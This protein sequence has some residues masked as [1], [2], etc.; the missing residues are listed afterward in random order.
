M[1]GLVCVVMGA[2]MVGVIATPMWAAQA[3][4]GVLLH[5]EVW[6]GDVLL[7]GDVVVPAGITLRLHDNV[8]LLYADSDVKNYGTDATLPELVVAGRLILPDSGL[9]LDA[10]VG[11]KAGTTLYIEPSDIDVTPFKEE[12][13]RWKRQYFWLWGTVGAF[14]IFT[15]ALI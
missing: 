10:P 13:G 3:K 9:N 11:A 14:M 2:Y 4:H 8:R 1:R 12:F 6:S 15:A 5:D 7:V